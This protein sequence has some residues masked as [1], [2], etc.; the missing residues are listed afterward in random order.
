[1]ADLAPKTRTAVRAL[2]DL[3]TTLDDEL[4]EGDRALRDEASQLEVHRWIFSTLQVALDTQVWADADKP[5]FVD[6]VGPYKKWGGDNPDAF[7][8]YTPLDPALT[9]RVTG[10]PGDAVYYSFSVYGGPDD[11][12]Y[13]E[14]MVGWVNDRDL[15]P[16]PDGT[17]TFT[18]SPDP[19]DGPGVTL[20][21]DAVAGITRDYLDDRRTGERMTWHIECLNG[22]DTYEQH[23]AD[24]ARRFTNAATW[25][26]EQVAMVPVWPGEPN[27]VQEPYPVPTATFGW[28]AGD[29][30][31]AMGRFSLTNDEALVIEGRSPACAFWNLCLW[32]SLLHSYNSDYDQVSINGSQV[33]LDEDGSWRI[34]VS[35]HDP[36]VP[37]WVATQ[38]HQEG[39]LWFR[40]FLPEATPERPTTRVVALPDL[41]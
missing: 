20:E 30:A 40:W 1:M 36:G 5:R 8:Q 25:L 9:Y 2:I 31:Y 13:S 22:S 32:N 34:V 19:F 33:E 4:V 26:R 41:F 21:P 10:H 37:N 38:G 12:R 23:D 15:T 28:A 39:L 24:M 7:Y 14:R 11:G 35:D 18:L 17:V 3:L 29:A 27:E 6:I 16:G